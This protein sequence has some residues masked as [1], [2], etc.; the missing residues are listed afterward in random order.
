MAILSNARADMRTLKKG[1]R[2]EGRKERDQTR[3]IE[4]ENGG[5][6]PLSMHPLPPTPSLASPRPHAAPA[7]PSLPEEVWAPGP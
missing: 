4:E 1:R 5:T 7:L 6:S 2:R 3:C